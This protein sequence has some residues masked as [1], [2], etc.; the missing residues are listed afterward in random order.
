MVIL[1]RRERK[2]YLATFEYDSH[3]MRMDYIKT[4]CES[5]KVHPVKECWRKQFGNYQMLI[6]CRKEQSKSL[7]YELKKA[8]R[9]DKGKTKYL[10]V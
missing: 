3:N 8:I 2:Y 6:S 1:D 4:C 7:E 9:N 5:R 10:E